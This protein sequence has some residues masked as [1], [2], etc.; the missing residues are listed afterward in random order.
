MSFALFYHRFIYIYIYIFL[1]VYLHYYY[2]LFKSIYLFLYIIITMSR[3]AEINVSYL[4]LYHH[5]L[6]SI[7]K[8]F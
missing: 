5:T 7:A 1:L 6:K 2:S 4:I 8:V 3:C